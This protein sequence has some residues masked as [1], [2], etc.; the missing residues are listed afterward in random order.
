[1]GTRGRVTRSIVEDRFSFIGGTEEER[2]VCENVIKFYKETAHNIA[3]VLP[4]GRNKNMA[5]SCLEQ[6]MYWSQRS[7]VDGIRHN[8]PVNYQ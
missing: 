5:I 8:R 4:E 2:E 6:A 3:E 7:A 1:M